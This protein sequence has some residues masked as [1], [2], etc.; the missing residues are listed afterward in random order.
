MAHFVGL[1]VSVKETSVCVVDDAGKAVCERKVPTDSLSQNQSGGSWAV[2]RSRRSGT[3]HTIAAAPD[4][5]FRNATS[6]QEDV[7]AAPLL[8]ISIHAWL[9]AGRAPRQAEAVDENVEG[10]ELQSRTVRL[11]R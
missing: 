1:D 8:A 2:K 7:Q 6:A 11:L 9:T 5:A 4:R 10:K 3:R